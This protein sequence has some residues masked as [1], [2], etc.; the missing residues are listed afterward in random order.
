MLKI[1]AKI[2]HCQN[3]FGFCMLVCLGA[4]NNAPSFFFFTRFC[5]VVEISSMQKTLAF[6]L[7]ASCFQ[8]KTKKMFSFAEQCHQWS[9]SLA[10]SCSSDTIVAKCYIFLK[11]KK[12][13]FFNISILAPGFNVVHGHQAFTFCCDIGLTQRRPFFPCEFLLFFLKP[14]H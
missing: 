7:V 2:E 4:L 10:A 14:K 11:K 13:H 8:S 1:F 12:Q 3:N 5:F 9:I 6:L